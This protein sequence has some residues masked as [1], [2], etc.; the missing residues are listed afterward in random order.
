MLADLP[1]LCISSID[2][3]FF[4]VSKYSYSY[5]RWIACTFTIDT[6]YN[7]YPVNVNSCSTYGIYLLL[8]AIGY[9]FFFHNC[10]LIHIYFLIIKGIASASLY[11]YTL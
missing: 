3:P 5:F 6:L 7:G 9:H 10:S 11:K 2:T 1:M 8:S 4:V